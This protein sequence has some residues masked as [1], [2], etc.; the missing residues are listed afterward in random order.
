[1]LA[2]FPAALLLLLLV[3]SCVTTNE[4]DLHAYFARRGL[5]VTQG[6][7]PEGAQ[8]LEVISYYKSGF[9]LFGGLPVVE[10]KLEAAVD[11]ITAR[12]QEMEADGIAHLDFQYDP[13][14]LFKFS[15][16]PIP[17][18]S[19]WIHVSGMAYQLQPDEGE[20]LERPAGV[21]TEP[22]S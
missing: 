5:E 18:W 13:A 10:V 17:D 19:S 4:A 7:A 11:W 12:A 6:R 21:E 8:P 20:G 2:R 1:M 9:Y 15:V 14:S 3:P 16:F 22:A